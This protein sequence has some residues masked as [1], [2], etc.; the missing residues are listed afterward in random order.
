MIRTLPAAFLLVLWGCIIPS[1]TAVVLSTPETLTPLFTPTSVPTPSPTPDP[2][3]QELPGRD[4]AEI[5]ARLGRIPPGPIPTPTPATY[6]PGEEAIFWVVDHPATRYFTTTA[7]LLILTANFCVWVEKGREID[8]EALR[9]SIRLFERSVYPRI[10]ETLGPPFP[11]PLNDSCIHIFNG[12]IPGVGGYFSGSDAY[13]RQIHQYSNERPVLYLNIGVLK[14]GTKHYL[15]VLA[16]ELHHMLQWYTD[17]NEDTWVNEGFSQMA[18]FITG[19]SDDGSARAFLAQPDTQLT[20]WPDDPDK[21]Y[22]NYGASFLFMAYFFERFGEKAFQELV[23]SPLNGPYAF[24]KILAPYG[25]SF[26]D[27]F[28]DWVIANYVDDPD[29]AY[30][31]QKLDHPKPKLTAAIT[32]IPITLTETVHQYGADYFKIQTEEPVLLRFS[33]NL[34]VTLGPQSPHSGKF[35][36]WSG[37]GDESDSTLTRHFNLKSTDKATLR[38][39]AWYDLEEDYDYVY[40]EV[41]SDGGS[42]WE[43]LRGIHSTEDNPIGNNFGYGYTGKSRGWIEEEIDLTP[44]TGREILLRF[45]LITDDAV[46][47]PGFF[48]DDVA[49]PEIGYYEDFEK[50]YGLWVPNG[51]VYT[52]GIVEQNWTIQT[53]EGDKPPKV[54]RWKPVDFPFE[55]K[56]NPGTVVVVSALAPATSE[57]A[58]YALT[59]TQVPPGQ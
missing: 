9:D 7:D 4:L 14:P 35:M 49:I 43:I 13:P 55:V 52:D 2:I 36:W 48:L 59:F 40:V 51:F 6:H 56:L 42:T 20:S 57:P 28:A 41:S 24:N 22:P 58:S 19:L 39:W 38:F 29:S 44:W 8:Q 33:G 54:R 26:E 16:H 11:V 50:G 3:P 32:S 30:G 1:P 18:E 46:N 53:I 21:A 5:A 45:E 37:R 15:S 23:R 31:Y 12:L 27:F 17:R 34:T 25:L 47:R 10:M